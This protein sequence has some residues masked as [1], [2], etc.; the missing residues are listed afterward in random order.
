MKEGAFAGVGLTALIYCFFSLC[1]IIS[2]LVWLLLDLQL[3]GSLA[4]GFLDGWIFYIGIMLVAVAVIDSF[5]VR[6][7]SSRVILSHAA[8]VAAISFTVY[9][10][11][12]HPDVLY[13]FGVLWFVH[14]MRSL[15]LLWAG[16]T[17]WWLWPAWIR[18]CTV[19]LLLFLFY[20]RMIP[21]G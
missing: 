3:C 14:A 8:W 11:L 13:M 17:G 19:A 12:N 20:P 10:S 1:V 2:I 15:P 16:N 6:A 9:E 5:V 4:S 18:D 7:K 21:Y